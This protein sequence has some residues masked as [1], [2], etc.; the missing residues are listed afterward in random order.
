MEQFLIFESYLGQ[1]LG[2]PI[3]GSLL[4]L[5]S[6]GYAYYLNK[7]DKPQKS[8]FNYVIRSTNVFSIKEIALKDISV[9]YGNAKE[10]RN[11]SV[12][13]I[14][15]YNQGQNTIRKEDIAPNDPLLISFSPDLEI[16]TIDIIKTKTTSNN[17]KLLKLNSHLYQILFDYMSSED[18]F[19]IK[20]ATNSELEQD[21]IF[22]QID[23]GG[24]I[25]D[26]EGIN[27]RYYSR[28]FAI[29]SSGILPAYALLY[30][31]VPILIYTY[32]IYAVSNSLNLGLPIWLL[33]IGFCIILIYIYS[34][35]SKQQYEEY[36]KVM[37]ELWL[38]QTEVTT[39][40]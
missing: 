12:S 4:S 8:R 29:L 36:N 5:L 33:G 26:S 32:F 15:C 18:F 16:F 1:I 30:S 35:L 7:R 17:I 6:I 3:F 39:N 11:L 22:M 21:S 13:H 40:T 10:Q 28:E 19:I 2:S 31:A 25:I 23:I 37:K 27:K 34:R 14:Y 38:L 20:V 9:N 24:T